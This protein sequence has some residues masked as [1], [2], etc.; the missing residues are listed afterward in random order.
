MTE[1]KSLLAAIHE[2]VRLHPYDASWPSKFGTERQRLTSLLPGVFLEIEHIGSTAVPGMPAKPIIDLL[3][4]VESMAVAKS[5]AGRICASGYTTSTEFNE[6]LVDR[7]WFMR[8]ADGHRTHHLHVVVQDGGVWRE[9]LAF[10]DALR[11]S[12]PFAARYA[13]LKRQLAAR[14]VT[15]REAYTNAKAEFIHSALRDA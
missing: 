12:P 7:A 1:Q 15:D 8:W 10:R 2:E 3:A 9:R 5:I 11:S 4:G 6:T 13:A 14:H